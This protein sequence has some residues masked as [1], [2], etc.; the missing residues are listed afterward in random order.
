MFVLDRF[1]LNRYTLLQKVV[2]WKVLVLQLCESNDVTVLDEAFGFAL[3]KVFHFTRLAQVLLVLHD[4]HNVL[5]NGL[6]ACWKLL[7]DLF[8]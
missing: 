4:V 8:F 6:V 1:L 3:L 2:V 7:A 5:H